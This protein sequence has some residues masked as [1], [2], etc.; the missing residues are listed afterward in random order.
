MERGAARRLRFQLPACL[1]SLTAASAAGA[2]VTGAERPDAKVV[3]AYV[4]AH[5]LVYELFRADRLA[6][7]RP[8][9]HDAMT[10]GLAAACGSLVGAAGLFHAA[11]WRWLPVEASLHLLGPLAVLGAM[12]MR[13][14]RLP[15]RES[16]RCLLYDSGAEAELLR[17]GL[18][19]EPGRRF[20]PVG[21]VSDDPEEREE[22]IA[23]LPVLGTVEELPYLAD[24]HRV[25]ALVAIAP[26]HA[27]ETRERLEQAAATAGVRLALLPSLADALTRAAGPRLSDIQP[28]A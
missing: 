11:A 15:G 16:M 5:A 23:G 8:G 13:R 1:W 17:V 24:W 3:A 4:L 19:A 18:L 25:E 7:A 2:L 20:A 14:E 26:A 27:D 10:L 21:W 22:I 9:F 28:A 12:R 6:L